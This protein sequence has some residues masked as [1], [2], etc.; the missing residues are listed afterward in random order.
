M[1]TGAT[2]G[3]GRGFCEEFASEG[4]NIIL[5]SRNKNKLTKVANEIANTYNIKTH[6]IEFDFSIRNTPYDYISVF[7]ELDYDISILVNN[8][9]IANPSLYK[10]KT[11]NDIKLIIDLNITPQC[12]LTRILIDTMV[13]REYRSAIIDLSSVSAFSPIPY[14]NIY[15]ASKVFSNYLTRALA[16]EQRGDRIDFVSVLPG[17]VATHLTKMKAD[18]LFVIT[19][20]E[21][22]R[23][24]LND[25]GYETET[26]GFWFH[27]VQYFIMKNLPDCIIYNPISDRLYKYLA[28]RMN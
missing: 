18:G 9:G 28:H 19:P 22:A 7:S 12:L 26:C 11:V 1:V 27:K 10:H 13:G 17:Y 3:I 24:V 14:S 4:F 25:L 6:I 5:V 2:D 23:C 15:S 21:H 8:V 16:Y 20:R